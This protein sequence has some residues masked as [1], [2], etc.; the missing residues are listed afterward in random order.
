MVP[1][2]PLLLRT[3]AELPAATVTDNVTDTA[4]VARALAAADAAGGVWDGYVP[5]GGGPLLA[6]HLTATCNAIEV[7]RP[8]PLRSAC[9]KC[10]GRKKWR[11]VQCMN[12]CP[13]EGTVLAPEPRPRRRPAAP[14]P[15]PEPAPARARARARAPAPAPAAPVWPEPETLARSVLNVMHPPLPPLPPRPVLTN[16]EPLLGRASSASSSLMRK[17]ST[18]DGLEVDEE[19]QTTLPDGLRPGE[20]HFLDTQDAWARDQGAWA[21]DGPYDL[22]VDEPL[23]AGRFAEPLALPKARAAA[24]ERPPQAFAPTRRSER[25]SRRFLAPSISSACRDDED[26]EEEA[27]AD[28]EEEEEEDAVAEGYR[29]ATSELFSS[30]SLG[31]YA[32][33]EGGGLDGADGPEPSDGPGLEGPGLES[34]ELEEAAELQAAAKMQAHAR[35]PLAD[36]DADGAPSASALFAA[37]CSLE[38]ASRLRQ[39]RNGLE[40]DPYNRAVQGASLLHDPYMA[41]FGFASA[42]P[43]AHI[44]V[45]H[46]EQEIGRRRASRSKTMEEARR[47]EFQSWDY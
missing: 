12:P 20:F 3:A 40:V 37:F 31:S 47:D 18:Y 19:M 39:C 32:D 23:S 33:H 43:S 22:F 16:G 28:T 11:N 30:E 10:G 2:P 21:Q 44:G 13:R 9:H 24:A 27:A 6:Q 36:A 8:N 46:D 7:A 35:S 29:G 14:A 34:G 45:E 26:E 17:S 38:A 15:A 4:A 41:A 25:V 5:P 42:A 1:A